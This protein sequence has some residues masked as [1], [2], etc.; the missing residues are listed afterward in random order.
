VGRARLLLVDDDAAMLHTTER[1][2]KG[3]YDVSSALT[4]VQALELDGDGPFDLAI[5]DIRMPEMDGFELM[6][7][8]KE[9][10][11]AL[12]VILMTGSTN[13][14]DAR[15]TRA[16]RE[17]AFFFINK[18]FHRDVL[19][20]LVSRCLE[21]RRLERENEATLTRL[22]RE[23]HASR[24]FQHSLLPDGAGALDGLEFAARYEPFAELC[25]DFYDLAAHRSGAALLLTDVV[26]HGAPAAMLTG[27]IKLAFHGAA[28][29]GHA[30]S[31]VMQRIY[32]SIRLFPY[33]QHVSAFCCRLHERARTL[34]YVSAGHPPAF[35]VRARGGID[36]LD[37]SATYIHPALEWHCEQRVVPFRAGD[38][39]LVYSDG[40]TE[41]RGADGGELFGIPRL[42]SFLA[43]VPPG[44]AADLA[45]ET[46]EALRRHQAGR[47]LEDD[48]TIV[49]LGRKR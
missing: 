19:L 37:A 44:S 45:R 32:E 33:D 20:A 15:L 11:P 7:R 29:D 5:I 41:A 4:P 14:T 12:D 26:G 9:R 35:V 40:L 23:L 39:L 10:D 18:P 38:R 16:I 27:M 13:D 47:P 31:V 8:L 46:R 42:E 28:G 30:P 3:Q 36:R 17:N 49:V 21:A 2:L 22:T 24:M 48:L 6:A 34:E 25:G 43:D 1:I